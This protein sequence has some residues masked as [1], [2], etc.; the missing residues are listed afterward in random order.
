MRSSEKKSLFSVF[1]V[2]KPNMNENSKRHDQWFELNN[3]DKQNE[4][5]RA[6]LNKTDN[7]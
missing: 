4:S 1:D 3:K 5:I 7:K 6:E 2:R